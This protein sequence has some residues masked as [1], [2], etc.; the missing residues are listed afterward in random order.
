MLS[1]LKTWW[2]TILVQELFLCLIRLFSLFNLITN[3]TFC[4]RQ[5]KLCR[6]DKHAITTP[7]KQSLLLFNFFYT[8]WTGK[9]SLKWHSLLS[10]KVFFMDNGCILKKN[11]N[12]YAGS[13]TLICI[14]DS[15]QYEKI[16]TRW[17]SRNMSY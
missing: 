1:I 3:L 7:R 6:S 12:T 13:S 9:H 2:F 14:T 17:F 10:C 5:L 11:T 16:R 8:V 15:K 4:L